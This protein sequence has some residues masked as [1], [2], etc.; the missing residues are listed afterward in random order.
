MCH[1]VFRKFNH[2]Q[3]MGMNGTQAIVRIRQYDT[4]EKIIDKP[5]A[6]Q[7]KLSCA[8]DSRFAC[9]NEPRSKNNICLAT[10]NRSGQC[11]EVPV[12]M[13]PIC[14]KCN[15]YIATQLSGKI[16]TGLQRGALAKVYRMP[17]II[18]RKIR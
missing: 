11:R 9:T 15:Y 13:L 18:D 12:I 17:D 8:R 10:H 16:K 3:S 6:L 7:D 14:I 5:G 4:G 2:V 1:P